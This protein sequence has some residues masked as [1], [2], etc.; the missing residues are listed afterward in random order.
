VIENPSS[1]SEEKAHKLRP[2]Y[3]YEL[4]DPKDNSK[5]FYVGKGK[6]DRKS[7]HI[8][9]VLRKEPSEVFT[10]KETTINELFK[11]H[12]EILELIIGRFDTEAEA[13]AVEATLIHWVYGLDKLTNQQSGRHSESIR[14]IGDFSSPYTHIDEPKQRSGTRDGEHTL[15]LIARLNNAGVPAVQQELFA[16]LTREF[17][18][19]IFE[20]SPATRLAQHC[21]YLPYNNHMKIEIQLTST[22]QKVN[23]RKNRGISNDEFAGLFATSKTIGAT[24]AG[25]ATLTDL[26]GKN[27][28]TEALNFERLIQWINETTSALHNINIESDKGNDFPL[29]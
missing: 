12:G 27:R 25:F 22:G 5:I 1:G 26:I 6:D 2:Y 13:F 20:N 28:R 19:H 3:V 7:Q 11:K 10:E 29:K 23:I 14:A 18:E 17:P 15:G 24:K 4:R 9:D 16:Y 8:R 21:I